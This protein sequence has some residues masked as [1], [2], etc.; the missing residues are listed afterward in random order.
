LC[1]YVTKQ[2]DSYWEPAFS[3]AFPPG[4]IPQWIV[5]FIEAAGD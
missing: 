5:R 3:A 2:F 1:I 4:E